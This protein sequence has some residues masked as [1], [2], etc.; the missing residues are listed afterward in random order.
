MK[1]NAIIISIASLLPQITLADDVAPEI[2]SVTYIDNEDTEECPI[3]GEVSLLIEYD[4]KD[5]SSADLYLQVLYEES[6]IYDSEIV[7]FDDSNSITVELP[8][9]DCAS[10]LTT[11]IL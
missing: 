5:I 1:L 3:S 7:I 4:L 6:V 11:D 10:T 8:Y 2:L 9:I